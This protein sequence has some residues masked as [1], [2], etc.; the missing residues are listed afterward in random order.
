MRI[1]FLTTLLLLAWLI[2]SQARTVDS[3][4]VA[5][6]CAAGE[7]SEDMPAPVDVEAHRR[8]SLP[9]LS[10]PAGT[11]MKK[12]LWGLKLTLLVGPDGR[13]ACYT[14]WSGDNG[15][16]SYMDETPQRTAVLDSIAT[17]QYSPFLENGVPV[18]A[19]IE[20]QVREQELLEDGPDWT[21]VP[22]VDFGFRLE[23]Y[24]DGR[25]PTFSIDIR[26]DGSVEFNGEHAVDVAGIRRYRISRE[27]VRKLVD[28]A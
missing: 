16:T 18:A 11:K 12:G 5:R 25:E 17:W 22:L 27:Q 1:R 4:P 24:G 13:V 21:G 8:F 3:A 2:P 26:G 19:V 7:L 15:V 9:L 28:L 20:E 14:V 10:Y 6:V 23:E